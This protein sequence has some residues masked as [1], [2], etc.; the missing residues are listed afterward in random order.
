MRF[1]GAVLHS[2]LNHRLRCS[3]NLKFTHL[4][5][6]CPQ[7]NSQQP[8]RQQPARQ[9]PAR[10]QPGPETKSE[11]ASK[12]YDKKSGC[13]YTHGSKHKDGLHAECT[14]TDQVTKTMSQ[15]KKTAFRI[16]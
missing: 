2:S 4:P 5:I 13:R 12:W 14:C 9:Q 10:Q 6:P 16:R 7:F 15:D 11:K 8:A 3:A 1:H